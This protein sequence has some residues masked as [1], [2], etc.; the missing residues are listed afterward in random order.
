VGRLDRVV[1]C[2]Q[3]RWITHVIVR[4]G[5]PL[6]A[7]SGAVVVPN[8]A[9][10][11]AQATD[12]QVVLTL[13]DAALQRLPRYT[14]T[15]YVAS[16]PSLDLPDGDA[17]EQV[18]QR[19]DRGTRVSDEELIAG[20]LTVQQ[21]R[22]GL[23]A[24]AA[25]LRQGQRVRCLD[26]EVGRVVQLQCDPGTREVT[27]VLLR[28]AGRGPFGRFGR[29][30]RVPLEWVHAVDDDLLLAVEAT[31]VA[32][33]E[34]FHPPSPAEYLTGAVQ[35]ALHGHPAT[36]QVA[37]RV[38]VSAVGGTIRLHG[39]VE[40]G[41]ERLAAEQVAGAVVGVD[42]VRNA[43]VVRTAELAATIEAELA[44]DPRTA[45]A[46][47]EVIE[48]AGTVSLSGTV[49]DPPTR[50]AAEALATAVPGVHLVIN[51]LW[52]GLP[53]HRTLVGALTS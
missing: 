53:N 26:Q 25:V 5:W 34:P 50:Q 19:V 2:P 18:L 49:P 30:V 8:S 23:P 47:I 13:D 43:L 28:C 14:E 11:D 15:P 20:G 21:R 1:L 39:V 32:T 31:Q 41:A 16:D 52:V 3:T 10:D 51:E 17:R 7:F 44:T 9:I 6:A 36:R 46:A 37:E 4:L 24:A 12:G 29:T 42:A 33:L 38:H 27:H 35:Q 48:S 40:T 22:G 45:A